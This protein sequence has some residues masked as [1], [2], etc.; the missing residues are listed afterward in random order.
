MKSK[1]LLLLLLSVFLW[2]GS[3][4]AIPMQTNTS[5][6]GV[7]LELQDFLNNNSWEMETNYAMSD[8]GIEGK[9][10]TLL[11][12]PFNEGRR[13]S[14]RFLWNRLPNWG[15]FHFFSIRSSQPPQLSTPPAPVPEP[16]T[17]LLFGSGLI[18]LAVLGRKKFFKKS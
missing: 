6:A 8:Q 14:F 7:G 1:I 17:M 15:F 9:P 12:N 13:G 11:S 18:G 3:S 4:L 16:A 10:P 5:Q 2:A